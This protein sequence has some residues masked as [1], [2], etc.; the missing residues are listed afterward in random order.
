MAT[1]IPV[2]SVIVK[3]P[4]HFVFRNFEPIT[5]HTKILKRILKK[6]QYILQIL[7]DNNNWGAQNRSS[8]SFI[9]GALSVKADISHANAVKADLN[10]L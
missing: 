5:Q 4:L 2:I 8:L 10:G 6:A 3:H 1:S 9:S 7:D